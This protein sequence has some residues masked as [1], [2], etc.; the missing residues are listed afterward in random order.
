MGVRIEQRTIHI[1]GAASVADAEPLLAALLE[2]PGRVIDLSGA[3]RI[4]SA[5]VQLLLALRPEVVGKPADPFYNSHIARLID[6]S[7]G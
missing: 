7:K 5:V 1:E 2:N 6:A 3:S 4:H